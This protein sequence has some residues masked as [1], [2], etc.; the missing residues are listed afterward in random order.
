MI[1]YE[2]PSVK[3]VTAR[4]TV[5]RDLTKA[6]V[7]AITATL[8]SGFCIVVYRCPACHTYH[9]TRNRRG[10]WLLLLREYG[11]EEHQEAA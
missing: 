11:V 3:C 6:C 7:A 4:K 1:G 2:G 10:L 9:L 5:F 8:E